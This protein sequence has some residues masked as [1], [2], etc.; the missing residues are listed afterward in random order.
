MKKACVTSRSGRV[1]RARPRSGSTVAPALP[2]VS[3]LREPMS[4]VM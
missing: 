3:L 1:K 2:V 4:S